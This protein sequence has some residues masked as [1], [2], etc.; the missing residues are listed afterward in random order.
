MNYK[1]LLMA[2]S[3]LV[4]PVVPALSQAADVAT[5]LVSTSNAE[6]V[7]L[8]RCLSTA[9]GANGVAAATQQ[10]GNLDRYKTC[11]QNAGYSFN[12]GNSEWWVATVNNHCAKDGTVVFGIGN[13]YNTYKACLTERGIEPSLYTVSPSYISRVNEHCWGEDP[14]LERVLSVLT[15]WGVQAAT[16]SQIGDLQDFADTVGGIVEFAN[17]VESAETGFDVKQYFKEKYGSDL[18]EILENL[19]PPN[20]YDIPPRSLTNFPS[21]KQCLTE[22]NVKGLVFKPLHKQ[23]PNQLA[24]WGAMVNGYCYKQVVGYISNTGWKAATFRQCMREREFPE[25]GINPEG[26]FNEVKPLED[27]VQWQA[28]MSC[29]YQGRLAGDTS[30]YLSCL[31]NIGVSIHPD[32]VVKVETALKT[33]CNNKYPSAQRG[34]NAAQYRAC[35]A[36]GNVKLTT[37][38]ETTLSSQIKTYCDGS[39]YTGGRFADYNAYFKCFSER[40]TTF[41][42]DSTWQSGVR[43]YC[44]GSN[45]VYNRLSGYQTCLSQ[46]QVP[47]V[48]S[49]WRT[50]VKKYCDGSYYSGG[51][52]ASYNPYFTCFTERGTTFVND[53]EWQSGVRSY[54]G[55]SNV[56]YG[57]LTGY[58][59]CITERKVSYVQSAWCPVVKTYCDAQWYPFGGKDVCFSERGC[60]IY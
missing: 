36:A 52:F 29:D 57:K 12:N 24:V 25:A 32:N 5:P 41:V 17:A 48:E 42:N 47:Y 34:A 22:R 1:N 54:C 2:T 33:Q 26:L 7:E 19:L 55:S 16:P 39:Y 15:I 30:G 51:R 53:S 46:R 44:S 37:A 45:M 3:L 56:Q 21:Y 27:I 35:L 58:K 50:D 40:G 14:T 43:S 49:Y 11:V 8:E 31:S 18:P 4:L 9:T 28:H 60:T 59:T 38:E 23:D 10:S 20:I 6:R 13:D